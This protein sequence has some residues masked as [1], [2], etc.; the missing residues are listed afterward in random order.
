VIL[1]DHK[2]V[3]HFRC[4]I[5]FQ[6]S[7]LMQTYS[8]YILIYSSSLFRLRLHQLEPSSQPHF[9]IEQQVIHHSCSHFSG[10]LLFGMPVGDTC[11]TSDYRRL[12]PS[13]SLPLPV[14]FMFASNSEGYNPSQMVALLELD[15]LTGR[16][17]GLVF[18]V[19][20]LP[21]PSA[22]CLTLNPIQNHHLFRRE[23]ACA[24]Q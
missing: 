2:A 7:T 23:P 1:V 16:D 24:G 10:C 6:V 17:V 5:I 14:W 4:T 20:T 22:P 13:L 3:S 12:S 8:Y 11:G 21:L 18:N 19:R 9:V 15:S